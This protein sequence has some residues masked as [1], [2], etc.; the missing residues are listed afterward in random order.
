M[1]EIHPTEPIPN[2][3]QDQPD[4][5]VPAALQAEIDELI[6]HYPNKRSASLMLLHAMQDHFGHISRQAVE[7]VAAKLE[8]QPINIYELVTFYPMFHVKP[9]SKYHLKICRTLSC[10]LGG[11]YALHEHFCKKLGLDP[12]QHGPQTTPDGKFTVEFVEC[13]AGC[14]KAPVMMCNDA[15]HEG[16]SEQKSDGIL[17]ECK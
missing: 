10:A 9:V 13:L 2:P 12:H 11:S 14:G 3:L 6:T 17:E 8:L 4:F 5:A 7:W 15:F 1:S 16:V